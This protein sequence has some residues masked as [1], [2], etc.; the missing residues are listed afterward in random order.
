[1]LQKNSCLSLKI[2]LHTYILLVIREKQPTK[3]KRSSVSQSEKQTNRMY[4]RQ[5]PREEK[6][7]TKQG[8]YSIE[9]FVS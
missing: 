3:S 5:D 6:V 4:V 2:Y 8:A 1:M 7:W 9:T